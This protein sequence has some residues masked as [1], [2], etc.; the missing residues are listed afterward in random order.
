V[1]AVRSESPFNNLGDFFAYAKKNAGKLSISGFGTASAH[2]LAFKRVNIKAGDPTIRWIAYN[3]GAEAAVACL[4]GHTDAVHTNYI[5]VGEHVK[6]GKMKVLGVSSTKRH[7]MLPDVKTY[8]EQGYATAPVHWR[9]FMG[10]S[11]MPEDVVKKIRGFMEQ[12]MAD[13]EFKAYMK[14]AGAEFALMDSPG[15]LQKWAADEVK[16]NHELMKKLNLLGKKKK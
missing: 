11:G 15:A 10:P 6:A 2:F 16:A 5:V 8:T 12:T 1:I 4:G 13:P 7:P 14:N 9:G 3:G